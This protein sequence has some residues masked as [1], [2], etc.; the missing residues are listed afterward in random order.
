MMRTVLLAVVM[1]F[2]LGMNAQHKVAYVNVDELLG[3]MPETKVAEEEMKKFAEVLQNGE[4]A[5]EV[6]PEY[7]R[8]YD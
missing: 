8:K 2:A 3:T 4:E 7:Y 5:H 6:R 1:T